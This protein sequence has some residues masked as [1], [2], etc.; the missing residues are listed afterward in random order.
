MRF[1][2]PVDDCFVTSYFNEHRDYPFAPKRKQLHEGIDYAPAWKDTKKDFEIRS[3]QKGT[4]HEVGYDKKGYGNFIRIK[5][6]DRFYTLY[7]HL[8]LPPTLK[9]GDEVNTE[10]V[11]GYMG[12][13]GNA[14]GKHLHF[15]VQDLLKGLDNYVYPKV[16]DPLPLMVDKIDTLQVPFLVYNILRAYITKD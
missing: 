11:L 8:Q 9:A 13:T 2:T 4:V 5:H 12:A 10:T 7:A 14:T 6:S 15:N 16:V 3:A 1:M